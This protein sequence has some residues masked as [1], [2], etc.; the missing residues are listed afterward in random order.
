MSTI[1]NLIS[2]SFI[3]GGGMERHIGTCS[4]GFWAGLKHNRALGRHFFTIPLSDHRLLCFEAGLDLTNDLKL[5]PGP[6]IPCMSLDN[7]RSMVE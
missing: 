7:F 2:C 6:E 3:I 5:F 1:E 4:V